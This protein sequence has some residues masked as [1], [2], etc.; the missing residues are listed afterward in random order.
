MIY[1]H[2]DST[3]K[4]SHKKTEK[5]FAKALDIKQSIGENSQLHSFTASQLHSFTASQL[6]DSCAQI[7]LNTNYS[8]RAQRQPAG[9]RPAF[10]TWAFFVLHRL[11]KPQETQSVE[12]R[13]T[14]QRIIKDV[15]TKTLLK[16]PRMAVVKTLRVLL[17][18]NS[19]IKNVH[20][21][22]FFIAPR[23]N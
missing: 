23:L 18:Q 9:Q 11:I 15:L 4:D 10:C 12:L 20:G 6:R 21:R 14:S 13:S 17:M 3:Y 5:S 16:P 22:T 1:K 7:K 19:K 8:N 2:I